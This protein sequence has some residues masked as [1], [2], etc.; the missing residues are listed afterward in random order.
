MVVCAFHPSYV[1]SINRVIV[2]QARL[3]INPRPYLKNTLK[4]KGLGELWLQWYSL[5]LANSMT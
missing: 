1:G 2:V 3:G 5:C 4:Q